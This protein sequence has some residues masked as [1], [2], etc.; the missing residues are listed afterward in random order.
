MEKQTPKLKVKIAAKKAKVG[1]KVGAKVALKLK[2]KAAAGT[3]ALI[4][5]ALIAGCQNADPSSRSNRTQYRDIRA[6]VNGSSNHVSITVGDGLLA[7]A[8]GGG[9]AMEASPTQ[10]TDTRPEIA[11][12]VGGGSAGTGGAVPSSGIVGEALEKLMGI[13][14]GTGSA[15]LT[16][17]E[18]KAVVDCANGA[19]EL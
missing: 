19:C 15:K 5:A 9:D 1:A 7:T 4:A 10:T 16:A 14:G 18:A 8:D 6:E 3:A 13:V 2:D 11:V 17:E 12:G